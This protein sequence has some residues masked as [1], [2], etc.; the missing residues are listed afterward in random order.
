LFNFSIIDRS[1]ILFDQLLRQH[2]NTA[3]AS[4]RASPALSF[5]DLS[6]DISDQ[7][8]SIAMMRVNHSGEVCAQALYH[9]QAFLAKSPQQYSSLIQ[10]ANEENDHLHWCQQRLSELNGRTSIF[11]PVWSA[12]SFLIGAMV[13]CAGDK[14]SLGFIAETEHQVARHLDRH[15]VQISKI[16]KKSR[17]ILEQMRLDE[18]QHANSAIACG[19]T[20]LPPPIKMLMRYTAKVMTFT[21]AKI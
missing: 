11:N 21:A 12:S 1:V 16:D 6:L 17:A 19:A 13:A 7:Q 10:A 3:V 2:V 4:N 20:D 14:I 9:G 18:M 8:Q 5:P 15:L